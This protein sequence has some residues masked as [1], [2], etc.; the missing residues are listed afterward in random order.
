MQ[1]RCKDNQNL[2]FVVK[3]DNNSLSIYFQTFK[4]E[5]RNT[6]DN[7]FVEC[8]VYSKDR[9]V[10]MTGKQVDSCDPGKLNEIGRWFKPWFFKHVESYLDCKE[11]ATEY[12]HLRDYYH[13]H[14]R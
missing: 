8:L 7:E 13:R 5:C 2:S 11:E 12:I 9:G 4:N 1:F 6:K 10:V 3:A 14:S